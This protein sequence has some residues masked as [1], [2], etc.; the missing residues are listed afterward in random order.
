VFYS[1][2]SERQL[3]EQLDYNLLFRWFFGLN[4]DDP[5]WTHSTF[6]KNRDRLLAG[7]VAVVF[8]HGVVEQARQRHLLSADH[9]TVDR[10]LL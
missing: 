10:T 6:S 3:M 2:R 5:V 9:F 4:A 8:F 7:D 1:D